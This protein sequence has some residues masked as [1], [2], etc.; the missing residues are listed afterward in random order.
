VSARLTLLSHAP[1]AATRRSAFP[2][3]EPLEDLAKLSTLNWQSP[4]TQQILTAPEL[5]A[6]QTAEALNL[7]ATPIPELR[8]LDYDTW[9]GRTLT[10]LHT[11]DPEAIAQWFT[12]PTAAPHQGESITALIT[13]VQNWLAT[14]TVEETGHTLA[15]THPAVIRAAILHTLNA[16]PQSFWRIDI[17]PL[18]LTDLRHN[19]RTWTLRSTAIP[20][21]HTPE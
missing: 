11:E 13:R 16:P 15:I 8:D 19:G 3:N 5:R 6:W 9:Q 18:T 10:D 21:S 20:L 1:T 7:I 4:R 12:D 2:M 17:A 14:L